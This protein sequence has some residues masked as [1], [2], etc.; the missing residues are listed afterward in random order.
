MFDRHCHPH[1][2][3][4]ETCCQ[5]Y[6]LRPSGYDG[7]EHRHRSPSLVKFT[8]LIVTKFEGSFL[9]IFATPKY[10]KFK[11]RSKK[12]LS[13]FNANAKFYAFFLMLFLSYWATTGL[14]FAWRNFKESGYVWTQTT[15]NDCVLVL[16]NS[17]HDCN[18]ITIQLIS[19]L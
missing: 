18:I 10:R 15:E 1:H 7:H 8:Y 3:A 19:N 5:V 4:S 9:A 16:S 11:G 12:L 2:P 17:H 13:I 14:L 6:Q